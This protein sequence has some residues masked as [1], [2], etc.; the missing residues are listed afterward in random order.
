MTGTNC[1][2]Y[3]RGVRIIWLNK[4]PLCQDSFKCVSYMF[5]ALRMKNL[6]SVTSLICRSHLHKYFDENKTA[7]SMSFISHAVTVRHKQRL[8]LSNHRCYQSPVSSSSTNRSKDNCNVHAN[9][10]GTCKTATP[11]LPQQEMKAVVTSRLSH[12]VQQRTLSFNLHATD[13]STENFI[14]V[15]VQATVS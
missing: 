5:Q 9:A 15:V 2:L 3:M 6:N 4:H 10:Q 7:S 12:G 13:L 11:R 14:L 1:T 8:A